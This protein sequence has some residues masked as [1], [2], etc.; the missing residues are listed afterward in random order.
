MIS[1]IKNNLVMIAWIRYAY[2]R[3]IGQYLE[4]NVHGKI[5]EVFVIEILVHVL[6]K[7]NNNSCI[8]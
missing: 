4:G 2:E 6:G 7:N 8:L 1:E 5:T 3:V